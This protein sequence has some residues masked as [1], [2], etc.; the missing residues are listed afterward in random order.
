MKIVAALLLSNQ[1]GMKLLAPQVVR[2]SSKHGTKA[3]V[4]CLGE[5]RW[6]RVQKWAGP[7][8]PARGGASNFSP[9]SSKGSVVQEVTGD[10][11]KSTEV[12]S[13]KT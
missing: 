4:P 7:G 6:S 1:T 13:G 10:S 5:S 12:G 8:S 9:Q 3:R 2:D 11:L